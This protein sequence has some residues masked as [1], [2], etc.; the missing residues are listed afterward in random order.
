MNKKVFKTK[1]KDG[2]EIELAIQRPS[3]RQQMDAQLHYNKAWRKAEASGSMLRRDI[4][5]I[6]E[7]RGLWGDD[8]RKEVNAL[9]RELLD[10]ERKL[11]AGSTHFDS[12]DKAKEAALTIRDL[13]SQRVRLLTAR[14]DLDVYTAESVADSERLQYLISV[15][16]VY[17]DDG[18]PFYRDYEDFLNRASEEASL[19]CVSNYYQMLTD[20][21]PDEQDQL[22]E[23][24]FLKRFGFVNDEYRLVDSQGR[25]VSSEGKLINENGNYVTED[26]HL[27]D[28]DGYLVDDK[29]EYIIEFKPFD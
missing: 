6:A 1:D 26:G 28:R 23:N 20:D 4:D 11:R 5:E 24:Q 10:L 18:R 12:L 8:K 27:C 16:A 9:E 14:N 3:P 22:Y 13:R 15:T 7:K 21:I 19:D 29:G 25:L 17:N 2:N